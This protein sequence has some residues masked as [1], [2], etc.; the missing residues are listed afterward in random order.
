M[1]YTIAKHGIEKPDIHNFDEGGFI[2]GVISTAMVVTSS[3][4]VADQS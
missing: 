2:I 1:R 3:K 4:E